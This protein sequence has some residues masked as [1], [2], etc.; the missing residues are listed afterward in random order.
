MEEIIAAN[1]QIAQ[2]LRYLT[3]IAEHSSDGIVLTDLDG[4][5][6]FAN[7]AWGAMHGYDTTD[8]LIDKP[9]STFYTDEQMK[10]DVIPFI[11]EV[12]RRGQL[13]GPIE[14][15]RTEGTVFSTQMQITLVKDYQHN[16]VGLLIIASNSAI[17][18]LRRCSSWSYCFL[19]SI[20]SCSISDI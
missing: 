5:V 18:S 8:E 1:K 19:S 9:I 7:S 15:I 14:H 3:M 4:T 12:K 11:E 10:T 17:C 20:L 6:Q 16:A 2:S 13:A